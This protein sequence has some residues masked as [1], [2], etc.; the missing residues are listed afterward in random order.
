MQFQDLKEKTKKIKTWNNNLLETRA[1]FFLTGK[2]AQWD[3]RDGRVL[4]GDNTGG[5][6]VML[7][8]IG[9]RFQ[10]DPLLQTHISS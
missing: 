4:L 9:F 10:L 3:E 8:S 7:R 5:V 2:E 1:K 6:A